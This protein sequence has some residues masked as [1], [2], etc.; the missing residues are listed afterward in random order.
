M[1]PSHQLGKFFSLASGSGTRGHSFKLFKKKSNLETIRKLA[2]LC[3]VIEA[4]NHS[5]DY[6]VSAP[7]NS[8]CIQGLNEHGKTRTCI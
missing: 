1:S 5:P 3:R 2:I 7:L 4:W 8:Q 6:V